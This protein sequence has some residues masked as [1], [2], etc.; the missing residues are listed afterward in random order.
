M[1]SL[2]TLTSFLGWCSLINI[3]FLFF[4]TLLLK[5]AIEPISNIH[6]KIFGVLKSE[7]PMIYFGYLAYYKILILVFNLVPYIALRIIL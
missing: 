4:T 7:L 2:E 6:S 5:V 1:Y 3:G